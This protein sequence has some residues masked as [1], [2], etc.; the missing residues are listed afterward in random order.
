M[1]DNVTVTRSS[2]SPNDGTTSILIHFLFGKNHSTVKIM[3][4]IVNNN[5]VSMTLYLIC[6]FELIRLPNIKKLQHLSFIL[7]ITNSTYR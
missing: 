3:D 5:V 7:F 2:F 4:K 6:A 1:K